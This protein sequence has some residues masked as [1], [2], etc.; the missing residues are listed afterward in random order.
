MREVQ[1][2][3]EKDVVQKRVYI[4]ALHKNLIDLEMSNRR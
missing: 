2:V 3:I 4:Q 1:N